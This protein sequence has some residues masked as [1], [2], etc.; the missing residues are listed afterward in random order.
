[1][2]VCGNNHSWVVYA[3]GRLTHVHVY[4][5][6][7]VARAS[8][9]IRF[10]TSSET[11]VFPG[12]GIYMWHVTHTQFVCAVTVLVTGMSLMQG[13]NA[14][15]HAVGLTAASECQAS[16]SGG[17]LHLESTSAYKVTVRIFPHNLS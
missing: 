4:A 9:V 15:T 2:D 11:W 5:R 10:Y 14:Q 6:V 12:Q 8:P 7:C 16:A 17:G 3:N 13:W 1:M